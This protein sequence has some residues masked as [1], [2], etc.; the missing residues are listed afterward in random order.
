VYRQ[1]AK[2][3]EEDLYDWVPNGKDESYDLSTQEKEHETAA[4]S[5]CIG[6]LWGARLNYDEKREARTLELVACMKEKGW[7]VVEREVLVTS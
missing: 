2:N 5:A 6:S 3:L 4:L 1:I 7:V